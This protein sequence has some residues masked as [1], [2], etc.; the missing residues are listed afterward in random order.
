MKIR[1]SQRSETLEEAGYTLVRFIGADKREAVLQDKET[2]NRE[3]WAKRTDYV[4]YVVEIQG[5]G[6]E[7]V[8]ALNQK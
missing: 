1:G 8:W 5:V 6:Y 3:L 2:G 4:G 7:Y